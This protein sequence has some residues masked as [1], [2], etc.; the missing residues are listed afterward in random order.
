MDK[1]YEGVSDRSS[2]VATFLA[3]LELTRFGRISISDDNMIVYLKSRKNG[4][5]KVWRS[6]KSSEQ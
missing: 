2:R 5:R 4:G 3:V 1:L 6:K